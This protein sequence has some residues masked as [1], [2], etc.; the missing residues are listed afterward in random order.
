MTLTTKTICRHYYE[1]HDNE[2]T[3]HKDRCSDVG[4][5]VSDKVKNVSYNKDNARGSLQWPGQLQ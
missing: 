4:D 3:G 1:A 2:G 5:N